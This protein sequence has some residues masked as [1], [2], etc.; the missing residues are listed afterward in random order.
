MTLNGRW[1]ALCWAMLAACIARLWFVP[2]S[3]S[4]WVDELVTVFVVRHPGDPSFAP[5]PQVPTSIYYL[6]P[7]LTRG[8]FGDSEFSW[9]VP[10]ALA[11]GIAL[12]LIGR[13]AARLIHPRAAWFAIFASLALH[14]ISYYASD[15]RPYAFGIC[16]ASLAVWFLIRWLDT[17]LAR[18]PGVR[19]R[20][21]AS[22]ANTTDLL[23]VLYRAFPLCHRCGSHAGKRRLQLA[24]DNRAVWSGGSIVGSRCHERAAGVSPG[25][26]ACHRRNAGISR[27]RACHSL[28]SHGRMWRWSLADCPIL[29]VACTADAVIG[30]VTCSDRTVVAG[31]TARSVCV[32]PCHWRQRVHHTVCFARPARNRFDGHCGSR[33]MDSGG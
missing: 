30:I 31:P 33:A 6:L 19:G 17:A 3:S 29:Q 14:G 26:R 2:M 32:L 20:L 25:A 8:F 21:R 27:V 23:A 24:A 18:W 7:R 28:E 22:L 13:I 1:P 11:M 4:F 16:V 12:F 15:A 5:V 9:R 10:S